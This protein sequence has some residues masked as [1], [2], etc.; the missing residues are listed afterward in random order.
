MSITPTPPTHEQRVRGPGRSLGLRPPYL[1]T[2]TWKHLRAKDKL[3]D[4]LQVGN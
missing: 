4:D 1:L 3:E 2:W